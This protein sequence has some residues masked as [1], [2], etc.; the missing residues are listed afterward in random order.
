[1][2]MRP[3]AE[4]IIGLFRQAEVELAQGRPVGEG[5]VRLSEASYYSGRSEYGD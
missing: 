4:Q 1:M 3:T 5:G 2:R